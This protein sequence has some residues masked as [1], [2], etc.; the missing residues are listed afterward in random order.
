[1]AGSNVVKTIEELE[2]LHYGQSLNYLQKADANMLTTTGGVFNTIFGA[3]AWAQ[4]NL[5][6]NAFSI[7]PKY[8]WD[9]SG[10]RIITAKTVLTTVNSNTVLGGT[11]ES[12]LIAETA[13]PTIEE[14]S[15]RPKIAQLPF[16]ASTVHEWLANN[17]KDDIWGS[18][19]SLRTYQAVQH[20]EF[21]NQ[22]LLADVEAVAGN[23]TGDFTGTQDW[24]TLDRLISSDAE[25]DA[26]GGT[27]DNY[28][29]PWTGTTTNQID[30]DAQTKYDSVVQSAGS[31][32]GTNGNLTK[33]LIISWLRDIRI[34]GGK[35]PN[36]LLGSHEVYSEIQEIFEPATRYPMGTSVVEIDVNGIKTFSGHGVGLHVTS[37]YGIPFIPTKDA[38]SDSGDANEVGRLFGLDTSDTDGFGYPRLGI[39]IAVPTT[40]HEATRNTQGWPFTTGEFTEKGVYWTMGELICRR[41]NGN[42]KIRDIQL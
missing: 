26:L 32:I 11:A 28:Y 15:V 16:G 18:L 7:L 36:V 10:F 19:S 39:Q 29:D 31:A 25:E 12:G 23:T 14:I 8:V 4:L 33:S 6:A 35:D 30:R 27:N 1:M 13:K 22:M 40:Y 38:P 20:K 5:E 24:E 2:L 3:Y 41:F 17:S 9:K 42:G 37:V 21:L 34:L